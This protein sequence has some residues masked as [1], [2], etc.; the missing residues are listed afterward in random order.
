MTKPPQAVD[1]TLEEYRAYLETLSSIQLDP[2]LRPHVSWSEL[3]NETLTEA[4]QDLNQIQAMDEVSRKR[5]LRRMLI[6]NVK[7]RIRQLLSAKRD[8]RLE[9]SLETAASE[10]SCRLDEWLAI[11]DSSPEDRLIRQEEAMQL[12]E[13]MSKLKPREREALVLQKY[14]GWTLAQIA[15]HLGCTAGAEV[16]YHA[17]GLEKLRQLLPNME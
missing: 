9:K 1:R 10:S 13:A 4:W 5:M 12:L 16:G 14:H 6:N 2:R 8:V 17:R 7:D 15:D 3:I 11:E